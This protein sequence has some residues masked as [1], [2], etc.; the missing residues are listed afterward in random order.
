MTPFLS[1][2][3][4]KL[5]QLDDGSLVM[6]H[7]G[8]KTLLSS[9]RRALPL[10]NLDEFIV[11]SDLD[12][13]EVGVLRSIHDLEESSRIVLQEAL[14]REYVLERITRILEVDKEPL[15]GQTRWRVELEGEAP[16]S[17]PDE[18]ANGSTVLQSTSQHST[19]HSGKI[20]VTKTD[21]HA[22]EESEDTTKGTVTTANKVNKMANLLH[23]S[24]DKNVEESTST[25]EREFYI[26]GQE[27]VQT[28][29]YPHIFI[30]DT[31][32]NRYEILNCEQLDIESRRLAE[33]FF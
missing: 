26:S 5:W 18:T 14:A 22:A 13:N 12:G 6:K 3:D 16:G 31:D 2:D 4:L 19:A 7:A 27:D 17:E 15:T 29:R 11:F 10:S 32:R 20:A 23:F 1:T 25:R 24:R 30:V 28:A 33:R 9:P 21:A 8:R